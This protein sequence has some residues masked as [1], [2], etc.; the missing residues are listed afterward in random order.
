MLFWV[1]LIVFGIPLI[2]AVVLR[3]KHNQKYQNELED[4]QRRIA[5]KEAEQKESVGEEKNI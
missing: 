2:V 4:I 3:Q 5:E 1:A